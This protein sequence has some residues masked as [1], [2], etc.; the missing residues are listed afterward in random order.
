VRGS[1]GNGQD[2][3]CEGGGGVAAGE[4]FYYEEG[5]LGVA[6][7]F[8]EEVLRVSWLLELVLLVTSLLSGLAGVDAAA[9]RRANSQ[10][11]ARTLA[12]TPLHCVSTDVLTL[13]SF[14]VSEHRLFLPSLNLLCRHRL[15][16]SS[17]PPGRLRSNT[18]GSP[19]H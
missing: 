8:P 17:G 15:W 10:T 18:P 16:H 2:L 14:S 19:L 12:S 3:F 11:T 13:A 6:M 5:A 9:A 4:S 1:G 7:W